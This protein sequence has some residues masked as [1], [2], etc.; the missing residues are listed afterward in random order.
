LD[1]RFPAAPALAGGRSTAE[2]AGVVS[3]DH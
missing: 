3:P 2:P 1:E